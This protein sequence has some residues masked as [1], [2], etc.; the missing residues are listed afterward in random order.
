LLVRMLPPKMKKDE[1]EQPIMT[2]TKRLLAGLRSGK[3]ADIE[4]VGD[5]GIRVPALRCVLAC[6]SPVMHDLLYGDPSRATAKTIKI[7]GC[8]NKTI[9][10]LVEYC[11]SDELNASI[12]DG[13]CPPAEIVKDIVALARVA[14]AYGIPNV[15]ER[16]LEGV[17]PLM[18]AIPPLACV[19][20]NFADP[21]TTRDIHDCALEMIREKPYLCLQQEGQNVGGLVCLSPD[22]V[23]EIIRDTGIQVDELFLFKQVM[24]WRA[25]NKNHYANTVAI[26]KQLVTY[27]NFTYIDPRDLKD[28]VLDSGMVEDRMVIDALLEQSISATNEGLAF[29]TM[30]GSQSKDQ[31]YAT[32]QNA[33]V[34][35]C[36]GLYKQVIREGTYLCF[37]KAVDDERLMML[38]KDGPASWKICEKGKMY[39]QWQSNQEGH[40]DLFPVS[41]WGPAS[42]SNMGESPTIRWYRPRGKTPRLSTSAAAFAASCGSSTNHMRGNPTTSRIPI[43]SVNSM[44]THDSPGDKGLNDKYL[45][46]H[47]RAHHS[48]DEYDTN[49]IASNPRQ[50]IRQMMQ[51]QQQQGQQGQPILGQR[52]QNNQQPQI[53]SRMMP[54]GRPQQHHGYQHPSVLP[55]TPIAVRISPRTPSPNIPGFSAM[56]A[57]PESSSWAV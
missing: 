12:W 19:V 39:Y 36:N 35:D 55:K 16:V 38:V 49:S 46:D 17:N 11:C 9:R 47:L 41:G 20:F 27:I 23:K 45:Q 10:A 2:A 22:K 50:Q 14:H 54:G 18:G 53:S 24:R 28:V 42:T 4:L 25:Y 57:I 1:N 5:D 44:P 29:A 13:N 7:S 40:A 51:Q 3:M 48:M 31:I 52:H 8:S 33:G 34:A 37:V 6:A 21:T 32:I 43:N 56:G 30:R 15:E 26:C